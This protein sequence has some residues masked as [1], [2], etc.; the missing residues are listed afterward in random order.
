MLVIGN[1]EKDQVYI[2]TNGPKRICKVLEVGTIEVEE[3]A[4]D[5]K[6]PEVKVI[7]SASVQ[8]TLP[9]FEIPGH[10][11]KEQAGDNER[12]R[13]R[14]KEGLGGDTWTEIWIHFMRQDPHLSTPKEHSKRW[15]RCLRVHDVIGRSLTHEGD[16][17]GGSIRHTVFD[18]ILIAPEDV[19]RLMF[20]PVDLNEQTQAEKAKE[21]ER[22]G[23]IRQ[24]DLQRAAEE[25]EARKGDPVECKQWGP[26]T[27]LKLQLKLCGLDQPEK[28]EGESWNRSAR[29]VLKTYLNTI[30]VNP[31][32]VMALDADEFHQMLQKARDKAMRRAPDPEEALGAPKT[33]AEAVTA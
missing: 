23:W 32:N 7:K 17:R 10:V 19:H 24:S 14:L 22:K 21:L 16:S 13:R 31:W 5:G 29:I 4:E 33:E 30:G 11:T 26:N 15:E 3:I 6:P 20:E 2:S 8:V 9:M 12:N 25:K 28:A 18:G 27:V 1:L